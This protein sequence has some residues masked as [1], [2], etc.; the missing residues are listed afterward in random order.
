MVNDLGEVEHVVQIPHHRS[1]GR[2]NKVELATLSTIGSIHT[3]VVSVKT[4]KFIGDPVMILLHIDSSPLGANSVSRHLTERVVSEWTATH[5]DTRVEHLDLAADAPS[6]LSADSLGFRLGPQAGAP[7]EEQ[8]RE[9]AV[10]E[11]L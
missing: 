8:Q 9:N 6:H 3:V 4:L 2:T 5:P 7:S 10:S 11:R 1:I